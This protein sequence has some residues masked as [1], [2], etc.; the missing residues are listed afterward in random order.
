[1]LIEFVGDIRLLIRFDGLVGVVWLYVL[2][3]LCD[4]TVVAWLIVFVGFGC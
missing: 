2:V 4:V 3:W 1:M